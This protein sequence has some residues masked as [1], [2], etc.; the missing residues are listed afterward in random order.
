LV[1]FNFLTDP[2]AT[3]I[4]SAGLI[5]L[6]PTVD[7][8]KGRNVGNSLPRPVNFSGQVPQIGLEIGISPEI[9]PDYSTNI[10]TSPLY[11][12]HNQI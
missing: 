10:L 3:I 4:P 5:E 1:S 2:K 7:S 11:G 6:S 9:L 12:Q 8:S